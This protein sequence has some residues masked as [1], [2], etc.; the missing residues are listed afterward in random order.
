MIM[1]MMK[2]MLNEMSEEEILEVFCKEGEYKPLVR[3][4][5]TPVWKRWFSA[6]AAAHEWGDPRFLSWPEKAA[7]LSELVGWPVERQQLTNSF[8]RKMHGK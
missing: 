1:E 3:L 6:Y 2:Q 5:F 4:M 7:A 8:N